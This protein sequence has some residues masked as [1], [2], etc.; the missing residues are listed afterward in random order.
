M[1]KMKKL[2]VI[3]AKTCMNDAIAKLVQAH[4]IL[5]H[6]DMRVERVNGID[7]VGKAINLIETALGKLAKVETE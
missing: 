5:A 6:S 4:Q 7:E 2:T 1:Q 3:A